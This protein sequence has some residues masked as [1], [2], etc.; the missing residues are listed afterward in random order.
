MKELLDFLEHYREL[1]VHSI[2]ENTPS[3]ALL[4]YLMGELQAIERTK[5]FLVALTDTRQL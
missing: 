4:N 5:S 2:G 1:V 3:P